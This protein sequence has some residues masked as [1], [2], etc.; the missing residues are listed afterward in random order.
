MA[1]R[2]T[3]SAA[4]SVRSRRAHAAMRR[5][6]FALSAF[7]VARETDAEAEEELRYLLR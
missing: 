5:S 6:A 3:M 1:S 4:R 2:L 7:V